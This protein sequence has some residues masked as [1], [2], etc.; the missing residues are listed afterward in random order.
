MNTVIRS[1]DRNPGASPKLLPI[2]APAQS[3]KLGT[4]PAFNPG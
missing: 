3:S 1:G 2:N 4:T